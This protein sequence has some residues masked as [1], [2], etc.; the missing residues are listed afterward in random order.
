MATHEINRH[1]PLASEDVL[2]TERQESPQVRLRHYTLA[3]CVLVTFVSYVDRQILSVLMEP[4]KHDLHLSDTQLGLIAGVFFSGFFVVAGV[5]LARLSDVGTRRS[6]IAG[7]LAIWSIA[8]SLCGLTQSFTQLAFARTWVAIGEA[9]TAPGMYSMLADLYP[10]RVRSKVFSL[11][12][13]GGA[14]GIAFGIFLGGLLAEWLGWRMTFVA[15]GLPGLALAILIRLTVPEPARDGSAMID[16]SHSLSAALRG[17]LRLR[18]FRAIMFICIV[19]PT[20][21]FAMMNWIPT[22]YIRVHHLSTGTVGA[23]L[24]TAVVIGLVSGNLLAGFV[25]DFLARNGARWLLWLS[26][27]M[28]ILSIPFALAAL[29]CDNPF[30]GIL[31]FGCFIHCMGYLQPAI[32]TS[33]VGVADIRSRALATAAIPLAQSIGAAIGPFIVGSMS[34]TLSGAYGVRSIQIALEISLLGL[35]LAAIVAF[36]SGRTLEREYRDEASLPFASH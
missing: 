25:A 3:I 36:I 10:A 4:I 21:S 16:R 8:T 27:T 7:S 18:T 35:G 9:G 23:W 22:F 6:I 5:P 2:P 11:M 30:I 12:A 33:I 14:V 34:D 13:T 28:L 15:I 19:W 26:G 17:L 20:S 1:L 29:M 24:G 31:C 32:L